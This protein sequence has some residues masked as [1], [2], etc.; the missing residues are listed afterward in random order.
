MDKSKQSRPEFIVYQCS[1]CLRKVGY[2]QALAEGWKEEEREDVPGGS[3]F[4][5]CPEHQGHPAK[6]A[7]ASKKTG[8]Q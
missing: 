5:L 3:F 6:P 4:P 1:V 8:R 2:D 7:A